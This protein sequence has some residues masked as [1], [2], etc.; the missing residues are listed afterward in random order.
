MMGS[1][2]DIDLDELTLAGAKRGDMRACE[3]I[4][5]KFHTQAYSVAMRICNNRELAQDVTQEAFIT[6]FKR[7]HQFRGD[8]PFWGWLR[9]VVVNH[10]ISALRKLPR[11]DAVELEDYM[12]PSNGDQNRLGHCMDLEQALAQL[13][14]EDRMVVWLHDVEGYKHREIAKLAGKTESYSKTRLNRA[15][16]RLRTLISDT[17]IQ[18]TPNTTANAIA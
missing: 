12:T 5:R 13:S 2:F 6:A 11:H 17:D 14:D 7:M 4:Y 16:A 18:N 15:R 10:A 9:R 8:S 1:G 3:K